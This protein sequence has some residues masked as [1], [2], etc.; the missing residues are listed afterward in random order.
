MIEPVLLRVTCVHFTH[1]LHPL[2]SLF[3]ACRR[4]PQMNA[5][6]TVDLELN[7]D[8]TIT[9][10]CWDQVC[11]VVTYAFVSALRC[12]PFLNPPSAL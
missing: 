12:A 9:K 4:P 2:P 8:F 10:V 11:V 1:S 6:H 7:R 5:Y 3:P